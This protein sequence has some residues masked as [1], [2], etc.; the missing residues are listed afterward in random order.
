MSP[1]SGIP[2]MI[3]PIQ[4]SP[5]LQLQQQIDSLTKSLNA[6]VPSDSMYPS[7]GQLGEEVQKVTTFLDLYH[8]RA[9]DDESLNKV[10]SPTSR[11]EGQQLW[12][13]LDAVI[14]I[15]PVAPRRKNRELRRS[16]SLN[17]MMKPLPEIPNDERLQT[18]PR[19]AHDITTT[20][21][22]A[23]APRRQGGST[24]IEE[25]K[26]A[27]VHADA[28]RMAAFRKRFKNRPPQLQLQP[29]PSTST[30]SLPS[31]PL[32]SALLK[33]K[34]P[35][36]LP[37]PPATQ[38]AP[39]AAARQL[40]QLPVIMAAAPARAPS[41]KA[42]YWVKKVPKTPRTMRTERRQGWGGPWDVVGISQVVDELKE[43][44]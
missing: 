10:K 38:L 31:P 24:R 6:K 30:S 29:H 26:S 5:G 41:M 17:S 23:A 32:P 12:T 27:I 25:A 13:T 39:L 37:P 43:V 40:P 2:P 42:P 9:R 14:S 1:P 36:R 3:S 33:V 18:A 44:A 19:D 21:P 22:L 15:E 34:S 7:L 11:P 4:L 28:Q 35:R 8:S 16:R 20:Q